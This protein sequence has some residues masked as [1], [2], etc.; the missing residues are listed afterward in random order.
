M[1]LYNNDLSSDIDIFFSLVRIAYVHII[2]VHL[3]WI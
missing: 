3:S 2:A 1:L